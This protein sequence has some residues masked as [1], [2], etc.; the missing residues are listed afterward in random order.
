MRCGSAVHLGLTRG[1]ADGARLRIGIERRS[2]SG[3]HDSSGRRWLPSTPAPAILV[4]LVT[5]A[6]VVD[7]ALESV[8]Q[9]LARVT[10]TAAATATAAAIG[11]I[12]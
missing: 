9:P 8:P 7:G 11:P 1:V 6:P 5:A 4:V 3:A 12:R 2:G 10:D